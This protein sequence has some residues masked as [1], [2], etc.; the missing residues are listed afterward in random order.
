[1]IFSRRKALGGLLVLPMLS[2][3]KAQYNESDML[4]PEGLTILFQGDSI[5]DGGRNRG[6]YYPNHGQGMGQGY[7]RH[8]VTTLLGRYP[9]EQ[10]KFYNR[11]ISGHKVYQLR[12]RW[13]D[14]CIQLKPDV[15]SILIGV[16]DFWHTLT[17]NYSGTVS[18]YRDD[19]RALLDQTVN[20]LPYARLIIGEPFVLHEG[21]SIDSNRWKGNFEPYQLAAREISQEFNAS[22]IPYQAL[23]DAALREEPAS[24]WCPDGV[25]PS[26]A[27]NYIM[28]G[29]W[30]QAF[31]ELYQ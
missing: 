19:F 11:G 4:I 31:E 27:G 8:V 13:M 14:D 16:N 22:F 24:Y 23:F 1:M 26:M 15:I 17:N 6:A 12:D 2:S 25:H 3:L 21:T 30:I 18:T 7:V 10:M 28:A 20:A 9:R 5:T 29:A